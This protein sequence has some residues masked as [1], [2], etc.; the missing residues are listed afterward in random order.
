MH[1]H[2][3]RQSIKKKELEISLAELR[4]ML[5][6]TTNPEYLKD[7]ALR[8]A[9]VETSIKDQETCLD[10]LKRHAISQRKLREKKRKLLEEEQLVVKFDAPGRPPLIYQYPDIHD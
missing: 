3:E 6:I 9:S 1:Q 10:K 5:K 7:F 8:I 4:A 2:N